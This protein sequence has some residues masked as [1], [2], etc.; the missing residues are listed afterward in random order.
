LRSEQVFPR[1]RRAIRSSQRAAFRILHFSVQVDHIHLIVEA[2]YPAE[3]A[4]GLRSLA[5][6]CAFAVNCSVGR[7]GPIW[8]RRYH[9]HPLT[10]PTEVR[11]AIAYV[12]MNFRKHL[13]A[14]PGI[15]PRSSAS[16]FDGWISSP[17]TSPAYDTIA[18]PRTWL[19]AVGWR[20]AGGPLSFDDAPAPL[21]TRH[22]NRR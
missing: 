11:R 5:I 6:R 22:L 12:L 14:A 4:K 19:G 2:D 17:L 1:L 3:L 13:R 18:R 15:D 10:S 8:G 16:A 21:R 20:R 9:A 7:R